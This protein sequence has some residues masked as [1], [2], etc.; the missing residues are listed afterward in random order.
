MKSYKK[1]SKLVLLLMMVVFLWVPSI[2]AYAEVQVT[3]LSKLMAAKSA[4]DAFAEPEEQS[5]VVFSYEAEGS[6]LVTGETTDGWYRVVYQDK[7]GFV[8][9]TDLKDANI[10]VAAL[11]E[12][13]EAEEIE[14]KI[15]VEEV[16]RIRAQ[17]TRSRIWGTI[18]V[19]LIVG[20]FGSGIYSTVKSEQKKKQNEQGTDNTESTQEN[21][22]IEENVN[23]KK[24]GTNAENE[25][26]LVEPLS[27]E[28]T[29]TE[30]LDIMDLDEQES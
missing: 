29:K 18:I 16:E 17:I 5:E 14:G 15:F 23:E 22:K 28:A 20:I 24:K 6:V 30:S 9:K 25:D 10:D 4:T 27:F 7:V 1:I 3:E 21:V 12:E 26:E 19:L 8:K 2:S 11:D 13:F